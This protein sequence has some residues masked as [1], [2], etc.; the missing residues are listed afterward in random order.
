MTNRLLRRT[1]LEPDPIF[2]RVVRTLPA[3]RRRPYVGLLTSLLAASF[4]SLAALTESGWSQNPESLQALTVRLA[5]IP[6]VTGYEQALVDT[7]LRLLPDAQRD[8]AGNVRLQRPGGSVRR[9]VV[10]PLDERGYVV[11]RLRADGYL[12]LRRAPGR[13]APSLDRQLQGHRVTIQGERGPVPGVVAVR[14]IHLTRGRDAPPDSLF[15]V[16]SAY[17][18]V[19]ATSLVDLTR[20]GVRVLAP[21]TLTKRP[22]IYGSTLLAAP[23]AGR[24]AA[25]AAL[26]LAFHQSTLR[27]KAMPPVTVAFVVE[28]ELSRRGL[29]TIANVDGPFDETLIVDGRAGALGTIRKEIAVDSSRQAKALGKVQEWSLPVRYAGT[30]VETISLVDADSLRA[31]L[32]RW[33]GGDQ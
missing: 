23:V 31:A 2:A 14:S 18:D 26:L 29:Y 10:C 21:V 22:Q 25:C 17:V 11:G 28:Q 24:R 7:L 30:P 15:T 9:L 27:A 32:G 33:I 8:R 16:D 4:F 3:S 12:T 6:A 1:R 20:L 5:S 13:A 19:G